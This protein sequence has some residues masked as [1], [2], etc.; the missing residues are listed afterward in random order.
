MGRSRQPLPE[1]LVQGLPGYE[2]CVEWTGTIQHGNG[3]G[4]VKRGGVQKY[5]HRV[6]WEQQVGPIPPGEYIDHTC[7]N[8]R[9]VNVAH[10]RLVTPRQNVFENSVGLA[11]ANAAKTHCRRGHVLTGENLIVQ[12]SGKRNCRE[13]MRAAGLRHYHRKTGREPGIANKNKVHCKRGHALSGE[14]LVV[15]KTGAR[16]CR[17]CM[18][19]A[20]AQHYQRKKERKP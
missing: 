11:Q 7:R 10:L 2:G 3:Y 17:T 19:A 5:A 16:N 9:C 12:K 4:V 8:R 18:R 1:V 13:C 15:Q 14:N 20:S 6:A